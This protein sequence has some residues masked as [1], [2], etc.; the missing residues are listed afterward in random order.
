MV[1]MET[2]TV[3]ELAELFGVTRQA[4]NKRTKQ[5][6]EKYVEKNEKNV[7]VINEGGIHELERLYGKVVTAKA[8]VVDEKEMTQ[9]LS[10][11][12]SD[13]AVFELVS[14]LMQDKNAE[15][16]RLNQQLMAKDA[17]IAEKDKQI[18]R[19]QEL[20]EKSLSDNNQFLLEMKAESEKGFFAKLF[21]K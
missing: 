19:Q 12:P 6:D 20:M 10:T 16:E 14:N 17:Q 18:N 5:L 2:K 4:M 8:E 15:I 11:S 21:G 1:D 9:E 13:T 3:S 7:T